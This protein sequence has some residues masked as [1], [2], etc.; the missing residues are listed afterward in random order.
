[1]IDAVLDGN[2]QQAR[3]IT[4]QLDDFP[5]YITRSLDE[6][7]DWLNTTTRGHR[8]CGLVASSNARRLR[9]YGLGV[10]LSTQD[11]DGIKNWFLMPRGD[12]RSSYQLEVT[13]TEYACQGLELDHVGLCWGG[14]M[15]W[16]NNTKSWEYRTFRGK[17][18]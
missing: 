10:T 3:A 8:R 13:A 15:T 18:W 1:M 9:A 17:A 7:R 5:I 16:S 6:M 11:L 4:E 2:A 14:D 12:V